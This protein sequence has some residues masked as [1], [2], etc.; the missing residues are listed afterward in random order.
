MPTF[1]PEILPAVEVGWRLAPAAWGKGYTTEGATA[2][3]NQAFTTLGLD[4]V[5]GCASKQSCLGSG[6]RSG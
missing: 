6:L 1:L 3:L 4:R 2:A 5:E